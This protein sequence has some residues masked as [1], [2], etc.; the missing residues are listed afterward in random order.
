MTSSSFGTADT[1]LFGTSGSTYAQAHR[2]RILSDAIPALT[3]PVGA[4]P[5]TGAG[6][7]AGNT[8][9][10]TLE[11]NWPAV[12]MQNNTELNKWHH[13]DCRQVAYTFTYQLFDN[14]VTMGELQ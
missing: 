5:V 10:Q 12:R 1:A 7:V 4:N 9:M 11:N 8:D 3:L 13:S 2:N 6:I 14:I